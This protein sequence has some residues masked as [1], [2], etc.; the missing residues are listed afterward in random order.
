[1]KD[2]ETRREEYRK[3][4]KKVFLMRIGLLAAF[5]III[6][7]LIFKKSNTYPGAELDMTSYLK[8]NY[9]GYDGVATARLDF[10]R[11]AF[12]TQVDSVKTDY[13][14]SVWPLKKKASAEDFDAF[15][16]SVSLNLSKD[17]D[18]KNGDEITITVDYDRQRA[19]DLRLSM[20]YEQ[21]PFTVEDLAEGIKIDSKA[22]FSDL[23]ISV[24]GISPQISLELINDSGTEPV[25]GFSYEATPQK[26]FYERGD[27]ITIKAVYDEAAL[28]AAHYYIPEGDDEMKYVIPGDVSYVQYADDLD[29]A[30]IERAIELS[31]KCLLESN[32]NEY[33]LRIFT[34]AHLPYAWEGTGDYT[35][36]WSDAR[37]LSGYVETLKDESLGLT[38][39]PYNY[40]ELAYEVHISQA[41]GVGTD[42][43]AVVCF[44]SMTVD[45]NGVVDLNED[46][47][48]VFAASY[49]DTDIKRTIRGWFGD[50]YSVN[51]VDVYKWTSMEE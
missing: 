23:T 21:I 50:E 20:K 5:I 3:R 45:D 31:K 47:V 15:K 7:F 44:D 39:K 51:R 32:A 48:Q 36:E 46:S 43:E 6:I 34:D 17:K 10:D 22:V 33:G 26:D 14:S 40:L 35:F 27:I 18:L 42:A 37:L 13:F 2:D 24:N 1:M 25:T 30:T 4:H 16:D 8:V 9:Q 49:S 41:N 38:S 19:Q 11:M 29:E 28:T 12:E